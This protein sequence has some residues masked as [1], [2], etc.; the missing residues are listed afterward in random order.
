M[1]RR[2]AGQAQPHC[3]CAPGCAG[4]VGRAPIGEVLVR[5]RINARIDPRRAGRRAVVLQLAEADAVAARI[6]GEEAVDLFQDFQRRRLALF[7]LG[8]V[9]VL[10]VPD[11]I[12][13]PLV[14]RQ[15]WN[16]A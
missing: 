2:L 12:L 16:C 13:E 6:V 3:S 9:L 7:A 8:F 10:V 14:A 11:Q 15:R 4:R 5:R 1:T